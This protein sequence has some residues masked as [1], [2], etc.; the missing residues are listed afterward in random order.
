MNRT[1]LAAAFTA[2]AACGGG[3]VGSVQTA[4]ATASSRL[5][6]LEGDG[7]E[8]CGLS[9]VARGLMLTLMPAVLDEAQGGLVAAAADLTLTDP[10]GNPVPFEQVTDRF[11]TRFLRSGT[12]VLAATF[13]DGTRV[14]RDV[15]VVEGAGLRLGQRGRE[16]ITHGASGDCTQSVL[17]GPT[18]SLARNQELQTW[19]VP[20]DAQDRSLL[21]KLELEFAGTASARKWMPDSPFNVFVLAPTGSGTN[22]VKL[23]DVELHLEHQVSL[24]VASAPAQCP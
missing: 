19:I 12:Y 16:I 13:E 17:E 11:R 21:G 5:I 18:P 22:V 20:V 23:S 8:A 24:D 3:Q 6:Y 4:P 10:D 9:P 2:L 15:T 7:I 1:V 14:T